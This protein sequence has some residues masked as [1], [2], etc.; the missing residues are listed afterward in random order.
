MEPL[1]YQ[2]EKR[3]CWLT[4]FVLW[5]SEKSAVPFFYPGEWLSF[6]NPRLMRYMSPIELYHTISG[7]LG[8]VARA[9]LDDWRHDLS[10]RGASLSCHFHLRNG[11]RCEGRGPLY[12]PAVR[13][14]RLELRVMIYLPD[15]VPNRHQL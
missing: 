7:H 6:A 1:A 11:R 14:I 5:D 12:T 2:G 4:L 8:R 9:L 13:W 3:G 10:G 15:L